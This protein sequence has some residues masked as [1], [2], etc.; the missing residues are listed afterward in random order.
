MFQQDL[1]EKQAF[2]Y[3]YNK[4]Y[5]NSTSKSWPDHICI[6]KFSKSIKVVEC[7]INNTLSIDSDHLVLNA[8]L[9]LS[10]KHMQ[11]ESKIEDKHQADWLD[12]LVQQRY[13]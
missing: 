12:P 13:N 1:K 8:I 9:Q 3:S 6:N 2:N 4:K 10:N 5:R 11:A 7:K